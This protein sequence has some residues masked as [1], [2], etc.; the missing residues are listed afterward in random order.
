MAATTTTDIFGTNAA[1]GDNTLQ[2]IFG[3]IAGQ[4]QGIT[5]QWAALQAQNSDIAN[6]RWTLNNAVFQFQQLSPAA[7][8]AALAALAWVAVKLTKG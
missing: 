5:N 1:P 2:N 3:G 6:G 4:I 7:Q 8:I